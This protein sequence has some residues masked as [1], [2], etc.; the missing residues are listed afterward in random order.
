MCANA[1]AAA[2]FSA[3]TRRHLRADADGADHEAD[4]VNDRVGKNASDIVFQ[5]RI[6]NAVHDHEQADADQ[7]RFA[8]E[9]QDQSEDCGLGRK[10]RQEDGARRAG[11]GVGVG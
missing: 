1:C 2:P 10:R 4:L 5:Q 8:R 6:D 9:Q 3:T 11:L 7:H